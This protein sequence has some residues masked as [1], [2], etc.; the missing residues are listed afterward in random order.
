M[1]E[2]HRDAHEDIYDA[3]DK[4]DADDWRNLQTVGNYCWCLV[5]NCGCL[6][7]N[8]NTNRL[9]AN[10]RSEQIFS[11]GGRLPCYVFVLVC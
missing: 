4:D 3:D 6:K 10:G 1:F 11:E 7:A 9:K 2:I 5:G 8:G